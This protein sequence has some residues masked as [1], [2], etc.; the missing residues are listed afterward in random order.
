MVSQRQL[1]RYPADSPERSFLEWYRAI[2]GPNNP[3]A[4]E[5]YVDSLHITPR[6]AARSRYVANS[7]LSTLGPPHILDVLRK[8]DTATVHAML[9]RE[10]FAPNG[11]DDVYRRPFAFHLRHVDGGWKLTDNLFMKMATEQAK[12]A[13]A[14]SGL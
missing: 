4:A 13:A 1:D 3:V 10:R 7:M 5:H 6:D 11:R 2:Q 8:G 14:M 9:P 12:K